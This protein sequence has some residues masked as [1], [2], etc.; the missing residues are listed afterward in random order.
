MTQQPLTKEKAIEY[1]TEY[2]RL[3]S[4]GAYEERRAAHYETNTWPQ[5]GVEE[6]VFRLESWAAKPTNCATRF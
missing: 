1:W 5:D 3:I 2:Q 6:S 4:V